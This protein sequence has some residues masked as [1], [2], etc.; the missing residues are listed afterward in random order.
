[1][2]STEPGSGVASYHAGIG[3][4]SM[5]WLVAS[6]GRGQHGVRLHKSPPVNQAS[7]T[8]RGHMRV[9]PT[10]ELPAWGWMAESTSQLREDPALEGLRKGEL[11]SRCGRSRLLPS[12]RALFTL[13][14]PGFWPQNLCTVNSNWPIFLSGC[15]E[16]R[17]QVRGKAKM[18]GHLKTVQFLL[19]FPRQDG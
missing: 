3:L 12:R 15:Q 2:A 4:G 8:Q 14:T 6:D 16:A 17:L 11:P 9:H 10:P 1:M 19:S 7:K 13:W 18:K 5:G